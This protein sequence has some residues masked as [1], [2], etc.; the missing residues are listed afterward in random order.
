[1]PR[2]FHLS[3]TVLAGDFIVAGVQ[4]VTERDRLLRSIALVGSG[5]KKSDETRYHDQ[6]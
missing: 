5:R 4:L 2:P 3:V 6:S 1:M